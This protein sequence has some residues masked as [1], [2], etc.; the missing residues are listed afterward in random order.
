E[1]GF[2]LILNGPTAKQFAGP[3]QQLGQALLAV[4]SAPTAAALAPR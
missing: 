2:V 4:A 1:V 3:W